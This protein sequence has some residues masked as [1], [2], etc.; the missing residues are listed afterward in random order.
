M[1]NVFEEFKEELDKLGE[2]FKD[3]FTPSGR[4][5]EDVKGF[6]QQI[7][8]EKKK[9]QTEKRL[10]IKKEADIRRK[11]RQRFGGVDAFSILGN[12]AQPSILGP[13]YT[14]PISLLGR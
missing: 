9:A 13:E 5:D 12:P 3:I 7:K 8:K 11:L 6:G 4:V 1:A 2:E 14:S 10:Q